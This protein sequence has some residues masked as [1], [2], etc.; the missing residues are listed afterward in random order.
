MSTL[1][2]IL[3]VGAGGL[4]CPTLLALGSSGA[5]ITLVDDDRVDVSNLQR[6]ILHRAT[7]VGRLKVDSAAEAMRRRS[8]ANRVAPVA[9]RLDGGNARGLVEGHDVVLDGTDSF[10]TKFLLNDVCLSLEI[11]LVHAGVVGFAGQLMTVVRGHACF[12]CI[13][14]APPEPNT[15]PT[16]QDAGILGAV[17]GVIG[18]LMAREALAI[19]DGRPQLAGTLLEF[20][21]RSNRWRRLSPR[22]RASCPAHESLEAAAW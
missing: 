18:G 17:C 13:F 3:L 20:D 6:Q 9:L 11:P 8:S 19:L 12:R 21:A 15:V 14:E 7:D 2:R 1:P 5:A 10:E 16:C 22:A 4:G